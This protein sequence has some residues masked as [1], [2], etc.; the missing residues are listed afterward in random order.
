HERAVGVV[1]LREGV[2]PAATRTSLFGGKS[3]VSTSSRFL[4]AEFSALRAVDEFGGDAQFFVERNVGLR[5]DVFV[6]FPG[7]KIEAVR[8]VGDLAALELFVELLDAV[9]FDDFP[10]FEFAVAG[11]DDLDVVD[12]AAVFHL[13]LRRLDE[14]V[15]IDA[16]EATQGADEADVRTFRRFNGADAAVVGR[17]NVADLEPGALARKTARTERGETALVRDLAERVGLVHE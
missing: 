13:A 6:L 4:R 7:G 11:V 2:K 12:D 9:P 15:I 10:G 1:V 16:R 14:A 3:K 8:L 5:D 17:V